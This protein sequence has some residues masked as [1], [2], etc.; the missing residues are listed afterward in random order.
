MVA[1]ADFMVKGAQLSEDGVY[2]YELSRLWKS[3]PRD[4]WIMLNPSTA[5]ANVDDPTIRRCIDFSKRWGAGGIRVVNLFALRAVDPNTLRRHPDPIGAE[6]DA[7]IARAVTL[8]RLHGARVIAAW[9]SHVMTVHRGRHVRDLVGG[10]LQALGLTRGR[11]PRHP[12]YVRKDT[13]LVPYSPV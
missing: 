6:N 5:D 3:A 13:Q 1:A 8:A 12:L 10:P 2:R 9:G 4:C 7:A 11:H